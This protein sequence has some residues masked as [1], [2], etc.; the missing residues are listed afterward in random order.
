[1]LAHES[2]L[3]VFADS[4]GINRAAVSRARSA[5]GGQGERDMP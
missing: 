5:L 3:I 1:M 4:A 2:L